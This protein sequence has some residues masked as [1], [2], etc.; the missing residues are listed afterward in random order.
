[1]KT[2]ATRREG[3]AGQRLHVLPSPLSQRMKM[4]PL[5]RGLCVTD[6]GYFPR[7]QNHRMERPR[8][9]A[10][11]LIMLCL[12]GEGWVRAGD[13]QR[14]V[15]AGDVVW[16][17][18]GEGHAYGAAAGNPWTIVWAHFTGEEVAAWRELFIGEAEPRPWIFALPTDRFD[19]IGL[20][21]VYGAL[22]HGYG[23]RQLV[24]ASTALR[25]AL[26]TA[27]Q[28]VVVPAQL[29]SAH[30]RVLGSIERLERDWHRPHRL[31][32][33]AT[34][35][36]VSVAH[37]SALFRRQAGFSPIDFLI[38]LRVRHA[39]RLLDSTTLPVSEIARQVGYDDPY[40]F[41]R[42]FCRVMGAGPRAYRIVPKG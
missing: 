29:R 30:E 36:G 10:T 38:R 11:N 39:C 34:A 42:I 3:F 12:S 2:A 41:S 28:L 5:L 18:A 14:K 4:H 6:A 26:S 9:A 20:D 35:A 32:E 27:A 15:G 33:L 40:Y 16:L 8:G 17:P 25:R 7:A 1:M 23:V 19:E 37:Y 21:G 13:A 24:A 31:S 22:E